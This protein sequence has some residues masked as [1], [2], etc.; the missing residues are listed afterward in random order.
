M[1]ERQSVLIAG[2]GPQVHAISWKLIGILQIVETSKCHF[3]P[4]EILREVRFLWNE[5]MNLI[6][7]GELVDWS[8]QVPGTRNMYAIMSCA[9]YDPAILRRQ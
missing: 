9:E 7:V 3:Q 4:R 5:S 2:K 6:G 8:T 1:G